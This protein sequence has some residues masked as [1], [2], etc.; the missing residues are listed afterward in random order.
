MLLRRTFPRSVA[1]HTGRLAESPPPVKSREVRGKTL[2]HRR[3]RQH[4]HAVG[5]PRRSDGH[6]ASSYFR[7]HR[8]A[9][10][11]QRRAGG[12]RSNDL[13]SE[14]SDVVSLHVPDTD[15]QTRGMIGAAQIARMKPGAL[16]HQQRA[17]HRGRSRRPRNRRPQSRQAR[18]RRRRRVPEVEPGSN[19][20]IL[21]V[22]SA[23]SRQRH[24]DPARRRLHRRSAGAHRRGSR[25]QARSTIPT[26]A[27]PSA[28]S[29]FPQALLP[30]RPAGTRFIAGA[31]EPAGRA[32]A[33]STPC[34]QAAASTLP[35]STIRPRA[36]SVTWCSDAETAVSDRRSRRSF[37]DIR[38][39]DGT[40]RARLVHRI[41]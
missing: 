4:R 8:Q 28:P 25:P 30:P 41:E 40:I 16:S 6:C 21:R 20:D 14:A 10:P 38:A 39:L 13:L 32:W 12:D 34:S 17:R 18:R 24:P 26:S 5:D 2:G 23:G 1:A 3:L 15:A 9:P 35:V 27:P 36:T 7:P 37:G 11:R 22:A 31:E 19:K 29:T 33:A